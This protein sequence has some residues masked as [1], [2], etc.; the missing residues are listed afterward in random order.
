MK[1]DQSSMA[2]TGEG[3]NAEL[4]GRRGTPINEAEVDRELGAAQASAPSF[5]SRT[6]NPSL[7]CYDREA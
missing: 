7:F 3:R 4:P 5:K 1:A 2:D 6:A